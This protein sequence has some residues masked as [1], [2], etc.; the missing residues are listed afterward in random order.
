MDRDSTGSGHVIQKIYWPGAS[1]VKSVRSFVSYIVFLSAK[2]FLVTSFSF[3]VPHNIHTHEKNDKKK[4]KTK[5][6][7][8]ENVLK[9][10]FKFKS[11]CMCSV[12]MCG[13]LCG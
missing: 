3:K 1:V 9:L 8:N 13:C 10:H 7:T 4:T 5:R 2:K 12:R 6:K 11:D